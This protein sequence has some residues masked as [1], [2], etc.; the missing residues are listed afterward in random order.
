MNSQQNKETWGLRCIEP[1][2]GKQVCSPSWDWFGPKAWN[3]CQAELFQLCEH[4]ATDE[5]G[6]RR[7]VE[8]SP[9][10]VSQLMN[11]DDLVLDSVSHRGRHRTLVIAD[12]TLVSEGPRPKV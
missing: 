8:V 5:I 2:S 12:V 4:R 3:P 1:K 7:N 6:I 11:E 10:H 9:A